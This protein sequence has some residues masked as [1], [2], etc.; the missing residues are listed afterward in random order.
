[1]K[2]TMTFGEYEFSKPVKIIEWEPPESSGLYAILKPDLSS[3]PLPV[4]PI[5]FGQTGN[6]AERGF[7]RS[8]EKYEDWLKEVPGEEYLTISI[9]Q[10]PGS[11]KEEREAIESK[12]IDEY[13][14]VCND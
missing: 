5:Y 8:H 13:H 3:S 4:K 1:M 6:F 10:M 9:C 11:T 2:M 14:P 7:L 12:L